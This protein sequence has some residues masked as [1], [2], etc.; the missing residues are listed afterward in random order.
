MKYLQLKLD[1]EV[2]DVIQKW[3]DK[4]GSNFTVE[5]RK[6]IIEFYNSLKTSMNAE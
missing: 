3:C 6:R 1:D 5:C 2:A 4:N